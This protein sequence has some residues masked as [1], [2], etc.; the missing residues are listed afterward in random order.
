[1]EKLED[2]R[3]RK[4]PFCGCTLYGSGGDPVRPLL[5]F[6]P[7]EA[8]GRFRRLRGR[9]VSHIRLVISWGALEYAGPGAYDESCLASLRKILLAAAQTGISVFIDPVQNRWSRWTGG[10]GAPPWATEQR[11]R[12]GEWLQERYLDCMRHC[13]RRLKNCAALIGWGASAEDLSRPFM[14]RFAERMREA[15]EGTRFFI[16]ESPRDRGAR[17]LGSGE[18]PEWAAEAFRYYDGSAFPDYRETAEQEG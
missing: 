10:E 6:P 16:E 18:D 3:E 17:P 7:E 2:I 5:P 13:F 8:E 11:D 15:R 12:G 9:G 4:G 14:L 1:M